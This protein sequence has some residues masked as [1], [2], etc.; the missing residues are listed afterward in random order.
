MATVGVSVKA[1]PLFKAASLC[2]VQCNNSIPT[3]Q[4]RLA[5]D[6]SYGRSEAGIWE[7]SQEV[8]PVPVDSIRRAA[9]LAAGTFRCA[10]NSC[11]ANAG[12]SMNIPPFLKIPRTTETVSDSC[13]TK[14]P[15]FRGS[16]N[17]SLLRF[18]GRSSCDLKKKVT[19]FQPWDLSCSDRHSAS[20]DSARLF[21]S[22]IHIQLPSQIGDMSQDS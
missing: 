16:L 5:Q 9:N 20:K 17:L 6:W 19:S 12:L 15:M 7:T 22:D 10:I 3:R 8:A 4:L 14:L 18:T 21:L 11:N 13:R 1:C 2:S